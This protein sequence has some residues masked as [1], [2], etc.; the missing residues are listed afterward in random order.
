MSSWQ[1]ADLVL[2]QHERRMRSGGLR[3]YDEETGEL[4]AL[5]LWNA[6]EALPRELLDALPRLEGRS[7]IVVTREELAARERI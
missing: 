4:V 3:K 1:V 6:A 7:E 5:E 2:S